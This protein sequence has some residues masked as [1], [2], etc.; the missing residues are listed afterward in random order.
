MVIFVAVSAGCDSNV[1]E[2]GKLYFD[3]AI[4]P[5][6]GINKDGGGGGADSGSDNQSD[7]GSDPGSG[8]CPEGLSGENCDVCIRY[9]NQESEYP[10]P[11]GFSWSGAFRKIQRAIESAKTA[12]ETHGESLVCEVWVAAGRYYIYGSDSLNT[13]HAEDTVRLYPRVEVYGGFTGIEKDRSGRDFRTNETILDGHE[14]EDSNKRVLHVVTGSDDA[15]IDGFTVTGGKADGDIKIDTR[16]GGIL[17]DEA[18][19][20]V[21]NCIVMQNTAERGGGL[22]II[23]ASPVIRNCTF[24]HN[25]AGS[26]GGVYIDFESEPVFE[27]CVFSKNS[28]ENGAGMFLYDYEGTVFVTNAT[29]Y[30][31]EA[32]DRGSAVYIIYGN[33]GIVNSIFWNDVPDEIYNNSNKN[34]VAVSYCN[35]QGGFSGPENIV[36]DPLF[37]DPVN[38]D[39]SLKQGSP[40]IDTGDDSS[41]PDADI[42]GATRTDIP[43]AGIPGRISDMGAYEFR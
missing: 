40:C 13:H 25:S 32:E 29:F 19:T 35:V 21:S 43:D 22:G 37:N 41:A 33:A 9:V 11:D 39:F 42:T 34:E 17:L 18:S 36:A 1:P 38:D 4:R 15:V 2:K 30:A 12:T 14:H 3:A 7:A 27:N 28:A 31:N 26:G 10:Y 20:A 6:S 5:D 23:Y 16:G 24:S 8:G